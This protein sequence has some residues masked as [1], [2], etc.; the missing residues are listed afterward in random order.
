MQK[1]FALQVTGIVQGVG[2]RPYVYG[3]AL[4]CGLGGFVKND[5][6]GVAI[7][8]EGEEPACRRFMAQLPLAAP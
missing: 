3:L 4:S 2:F 8:I 1:R 6:A 7:E 5:A